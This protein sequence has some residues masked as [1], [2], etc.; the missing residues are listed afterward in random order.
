MTMSCNV[1]KKYCDKREIGKKMSI[2]A[3]IATYNGQEW[4]HKCISSVLR[5]NIPVSIIVI[6][7]N[8][9]DNTREIV[10]RFESVKLIPLRTNLGFGRANNIGIQTAL[11]SG[12]DYFFLINQDGWVDK[13]TIEYLISVALDNP[14]Y[15]ILSPIH[16][17]GNESLLDSLFAKYMALR[18]DIK[19]ISDLY[20]SRENLLPVYETTFVNAAFW[21]ISKNCI[22]AAGYFDEN[23]FVYGEDAD[24]LKRVIKQ[25]LK[26]GICPG[27][28]AFHGRPQFSDDALPLNRDRILGRL[29]MKVKWEGLTKTMIMLKLL[30]NL[31]KYLISK[32]LKYRYKIW[33]T[34]IVLKK[35]NKI[36]KIN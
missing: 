6:D 2:Y 15:G 28:I 13:N 35:Y 30:S 24:Y 27:A 26:I 5:S 29:V 10:R 36:R 1:N 7:N 34:L 31:M 12:A 17:S 21:L 8:S 3:I 22:H 23:F 32:D 9:A 20:L 25:E 19:L 18:T 4:I 11:A 16:F 33:A 14:E